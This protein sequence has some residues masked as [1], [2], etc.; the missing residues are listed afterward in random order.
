MAAATASSAAAGTYL[1]VRSGPEAW[2]VLDPATVVRDPGGQ[3]LSAWSVTVQRNLTNSRPPQPGYI[4]TFNEYD[5]TERRLRWRT[6]LAYSRFGVLVMQKENT[7]AEWGPAP[8]GSE[9]DSGLRVLCDGVGGGSVMASQ[10]MAGVVMALMQAW[11]T[12]DAPPPQAAPATAVPRP[13]PS[14]PAKR[15][16]KPR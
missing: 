6:F 14:K 7:S 11:D 15:R 1:V 8:D 13:V 10:S 16:A 3:R 9:G 5:C 12:P 2:T 4:R